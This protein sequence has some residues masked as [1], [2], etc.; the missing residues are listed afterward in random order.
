MLNNIFFNNLTRCFIFILVLFFFSN[1]SATP[2]AFDT[3]ANTE[4]KA[5]RN[6]VK[7]EAKQNEMNLEAE[8]W[9]KK[10]TNRLIKEIMLALPMP[11]KRLL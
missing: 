10:V 7:Q 2:K 3:N 5:P 8:K 11:I 4:T 6:E 1:A 9:I